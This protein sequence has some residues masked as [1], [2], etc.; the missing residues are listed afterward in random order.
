M[1]YDNYARSMRILRK[2]IQQWR[3]LQDEHRATD[4]RRWSADMNE[5]M[6]QIQPIGDAADQACLWIGRAKSPSS[7]EVVSIV[8]ALYRALEPNSHITINRDAMASLVDI[9]QYFAADIEQEPSD[10]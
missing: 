10:E 3:V 1:K 5:A 2:D 9:A 4:L 7:S 6:G 8:H